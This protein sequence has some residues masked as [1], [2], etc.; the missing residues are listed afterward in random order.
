MCVV[1]SVVA[2]GT[3]KSRPDAG[4]T[5]RRQD[6]R[7]RGS[8]PPRAIPEV[9]RPGDSCPRKGS[10]RAAEHQPPARSSERIKCAASERFGEIVDEEDRELLVHLAYVG[11]L[12]REVEEGWRWTEI[13][14]RWIRNVLATRSEVAGSKTDTF[15]ALVSWIAVQP[16]TG[17]ERINPQG[18]A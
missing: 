18:F 12:S 8:R 13:G 4:T 15:E 5:R 17:P 10:E 11:Y 9:V 14:S 7:P 16:A 6:H 2:N 3:K 1:A